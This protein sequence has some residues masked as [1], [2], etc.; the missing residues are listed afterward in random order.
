MR[1]GYGIRAFLLVVR[2][3]II[4]S[5]CLAASGV[6]GGSPSIVQASWTGESKNAGGLPKYQTDEDIP[7]SQSTS[8]PIPSAGIERGEIFIASEATLIDVP[9]YIWRHGCGPTSA[10][11]IIGYWDSHGFDKLVS[12]D[13][14]AQTVE[15]NAM[16][17]SSGHY[18][19][20]ALPGDTSP[21]L[22]ADK[23]EL[24]AGDEHANDSIAD[25]MHTS[26]SIDGNY[27]GWSWLS[28][29]D[30][31]LMGYVEKA[32][33][34]YSAVVENQYWGTFTWEIFKNEIDAG[35]P[36]VLLVDT[37]ADGNT[38][39]FVAAIGY[40]DE[41]GTNM[42]AVRDTW[43]TGIH[44]F[45]FAQMANGQ[46]W[47]IRAATLFQIKA[48]AIPVPEINIQGSSVSIAS[49]D[50]TPSAGDHTD[51]GDVLVSGGTL[52][53]TFTI[54]N[55][56]TASLVLTGTP[57][58]VVSGTNA[59]DFSVNAS[60]ASPVAPA[61][62]TTFS[63]VF[64]PGAAGTRTA[65][66]SIASS[67]SDENPYTFA[68]QGNGVPNPVP[69]VSILN[70]ASVMAGSSGMT[71]TV[72]G[73]GFVNGAQVQWNG[74]PRTTTFVNSTQLTA[75]LIPSDLVPVS[76]NQ[77]TVVN[78]G[79]SAPSN[80]LQVNIHT[81]ADVLPAAWY[82]RWVEGF[83]ARGITT[84]CAANPPGYCPERGVTRAEMA[85]FILR[86]L[87]ANELP[88]TPSPDPSV[89]GAFADVPV[90]TKEWMQAW[91]EEFYELGIT[92]G[93]AVNPL[94]YC[95]ER[96]V[97][98]AEMAVFILRALHGAGYTP[99]SSTGIFTDVPVAGKE[100]M[101]PWVEQ[102]YREGITGGCDLNPLR[103]CPERPV[104]RAEM[105]AFIDRAFG[106]PQLP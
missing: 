75:Q 47:G 73:T 45:E 80:A 28:A 36:V 39:H 66:L 13:A 20:Y 56:G 27:Y 84:G 96:E 88:Y 59:A 37:T 44:W 46:P 69:A 43:D 24:P 82:W 70:P 33:P 32:A 7:D 15:V 9:A 5:I 77:V 100:W 61:G 97:T 4:L 64:N 30:D 85:V 78:P 67:D 22:L 10:G 87:H 86:A 29:V 14:R 48:E 60:P 62:S 6:P 99:P 65:T 101:Q 2:V 90:Q 40:S 104:T 49:G 53:R 68:I 92:S 103:Y 38:D 58:V 19:D 11:M 50:S 26:Q 57:G 25:F 63:V 52:T 71:L 105:A 72:S 106:F 31:A 94:G 3:F 17:A 8:G 83:Y 12:G 55:T 76:V 79:P 102:F 93:C 23:S 16:I 35:R 21:N 41:S 91:I 51:F 34:E 42:Y 18:D 95:P 98:R 74:S 81:F 1:S 89:V 54:Q